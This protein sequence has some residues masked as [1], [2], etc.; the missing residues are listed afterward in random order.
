VCVFMCMRVG[1]QQHQGRNRQEPRRNKSRSRQVE[2]VRVWV[3]VSVCVG[4]CVDSGRIS[5]DAVCSRG[6]TCKGCSSCIACLSATKS[7]RLGGASPVSDSFIPQ[8][9]L[10]FLSI[11]FKSPST[12]LICGEGEMQ[13][14]RQC[15][16]LEGTQEIKNAT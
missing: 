11:V 8:R 6:G 13:C 2:D 1:V 12:L 5:S 15:Q 14:L 9:S 10:T 7:H 16:E 3:Y 4:L